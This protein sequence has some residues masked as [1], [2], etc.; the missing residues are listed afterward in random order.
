MPKKKPVT[1]AEFMP[2][3]QPADW[4]AAFRAEA[5]RQGTKLSIWVGDA[6]K[7]KLPPEVRK[8][9]SKRVQGR[10]RTNPE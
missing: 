3:T 8:T 1:D 9:L 6:C 7:A 10:P 2:T 5:D 4:L